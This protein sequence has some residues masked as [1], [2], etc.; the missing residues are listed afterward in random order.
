MF[1]LKPKDFEQV[2][3]P[4]DRLDLP[5]SREIHVW[6]LG[7][8]RLARS[9]RGALDG[10]VGTEDATP[11]TRGQMRFTRLFFLRLLLGAALRWQG[12][13]NLQPL[14]SDGTLTLDDLELSPLLPYLRANFPIDAFEAPEGMRFD[15]VQN[16]DMALITAAEGN[17]E[18]TERRIGQLLNAPERD[19]AA[20]Q[21]YLSTACGLLAMS[22]AAEAAVA[23]MRTAL[24]EPS[25]FI[26][27]LDPYLAIRRPADP[28]LE[29]RIERHQ[30]MMSVLQRNDINA[31]TE[32][33][34]ADLE[35]VHA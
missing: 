10:H 5:A 25:D 21:S 28:E 16:L 2:S 6:F 33:F 27:F 32:R 23:C 8:G 13:L 35:R 20:R 9:L 18:D 12:V 30:A 11:F 19:L 3:M 17:A 24:S 29:R 4:I 22:G 1:D 26:P 31:W 15:Y 7:L 14:Q 34:V